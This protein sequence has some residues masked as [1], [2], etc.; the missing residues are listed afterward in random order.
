MKKRLLYL[1]TLPHDLVVWVLLLAIWLL[2]GHKLRIEG[3][4]LACDLKRNSWPMNSFHGF[5]G[6]GWYSK[7][8]GTTLGHAIMY[9]FNPEHGTKSHE[10]SHIEF[11]QVSMVSSCLLGLVAWAASGS[12]CVG[13]PVW[14]LGFVSSLVAGWFVAWMRGEDVYSSSVHEEHAYALGDVTWDR[15]KEYPQKDKNK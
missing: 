4:A 15:N 1:F 9:G 7:W 8:G 3:M 6:S 10:H 13:F 2:W 5:P 14:L 12:L 11:Y